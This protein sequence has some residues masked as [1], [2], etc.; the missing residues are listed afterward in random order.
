M[1]AVRRL[2]TD[3]LP[4]PMSV[5]DIDGPPGAPALVLLHGWMATAALNWYGTF[6]PLS[7]HWR[8]VAPNLRGHG[9]SGMRSPAFSVQGCADDVAALIERLHLDQPVAVGYSM[10]GA[11]AQMLASRHSDK[12]DGVVLCATAARFNEPGAVDVAVRQFG[13]GAALVYR[14]APPQAAQFLRWQVGRYDRRTNQGPRPGN[15]S[16]VGAAQAEGETTSTAGWMLNERCQ[17]HLAGFLEAGVA[18]NN[19]DSRAWLADIKVPSAVVM[20]EQDTV[21]APWRQQEM[22]RL[23]SAQVFPVNGGHD[24]VGAKRREFVAALAQACDAVTGSRY[25]GSIPPG[26]H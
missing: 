6:G 25:A 8:V 3:G 7:R 21:V 24:A 17:S 2:V 11:V 12:L 19:W 18:L 5:W 9:A 13:R 1:A 15:M 23:L 26:V 10:G 20:T 4:W 22:A 14:A 16:R